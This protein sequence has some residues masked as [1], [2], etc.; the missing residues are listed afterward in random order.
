MSTNPSRRS[1]G[2]PEP[3]VFDPDALVAERQ[4]ADFLGVTTRALQKWR[5][6]GAGPRY[7]RISSRCIRYRRRDLIAWAESHLR[8]S[9]AE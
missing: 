8:S 7:V 4:A 3:T 9:T 1:H 5:A 2:N 6:T